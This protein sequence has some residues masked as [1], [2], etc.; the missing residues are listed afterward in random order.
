VITENGKEK[1][2]GQG[3][4]QEEEVNRVVAGVNGTGGPVPFTLSM[5]LVQTVRCF[6]FNARYRRKKNPSFSDFSA[7]GGCQG[8]DSSL[9]RR[10]RRP[11]WD[12]SRNNGPL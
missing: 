6:S 9:V 3:K 11:K 5:C 2:E 4:G 12:A 7:D 10:N 1:E 8:G